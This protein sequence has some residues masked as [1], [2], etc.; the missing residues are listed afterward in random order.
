MRSFPA[1][2]AAASLAA[3]YLHYAAA[4]K[5]GLDG[6][7]LVLWLVLFVISAGVALKRTLEQP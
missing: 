5:L 6:R 4:L 2:A 7:P 3:G 1:F